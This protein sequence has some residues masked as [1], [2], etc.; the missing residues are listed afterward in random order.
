MQEPNKNDV[1]EIVADAVSEQPETGNLTADKKNV[2]V[3]SVLRELFSPQKRKKTV[4][5]LV[6]AVLLIAVVT[7]VLVYLSPSSVAKRYMDAWNWQNYPKLQRVMTYDWYAYVLDGDSEEEYFEDKS[8]FYDEDIASW[9]DLAKYN[10]QATIE[11]YEDIIG[12]FS[13]SMEVTRVKEMSMNRVEDEYDW[14]L[15]NLEKDQQFDPDEISDAKEVFVKVKV[16]GEDD[17]LRN[18]YAVCLVKMGGLWKAL[19]CGPADD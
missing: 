12:D 9:N 13:I 17:T 6:A 7:G 19:G 5:I 4:G 1:P 10:K 11:N 14:I 16:E 15:E 8:D 3:L 2:D 18:T